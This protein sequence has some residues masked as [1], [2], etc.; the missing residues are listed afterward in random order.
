MGEQKMP[1]WALPGLAL[2]AEMIFAGVLVATCFIDDKS[3]QAAMFGMA[4][5]AAGQVMQ[6]FFGSSAGSQ[7]KDD[8][9]ANAAASRP[10]APPAP[11][12]IVP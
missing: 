12:V 4:G 3:L 11:T 5:A 2:V 6:Y 7:K 9:I 10:A 8:A 1:W